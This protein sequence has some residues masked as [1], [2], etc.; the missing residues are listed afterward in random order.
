MKQVYISQSFK[1][2][3]SILDGY[4][5]VFTIIDANLKPFVN[6]F[7]GFNPIWIQTSEINK[8][9]ETVEEITGQL[10]E[11]GAHR[12][13]FI[14][15]VGG[16]ITTDIAG[17]VASTY[18]RGVKF[19]FV[20]TTLLAQADA[21]IGGKNGVNF[22]SYKNIIG[23][24]TQPEWIY[25]CPKV[26]S[27]LSLREFR[28]GVAEVLKTLI[29]FDREYY[30]VALD[31]FS[32][33]QQIY[34]KYNTYTPDGEFFKIQLLTDIIGKCAQYKSAVV[35]RDEFER[36]E[37][38]LLNFGHTFAHAIEKICG[39]AQNGEYELNGGAIMHGEAVAIGIVMAAKLSGRMGMASNGFVQKLENDLKSVGLPTEIPC[40]PVTGERISM[41]QIVDALKKDKKVSGEHINFILPQ[42]IGSVKDMKILIKDLEEVAGDLC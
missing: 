41:A 15:G 25:I 42:E 33:L 7:N 26:L 12:D 37:R 22:N 4:G 32:E 34:E 31:Y 20:P 23:T 1:E 19:G 17:F 13:S 36:G 18:K 10:L 14:I 38:R 28:A 40:N 27:S 8:T 5:S 35:E 29:L 16:G 39:E 3:K 2:L 9:L 24:I 6:I 21:S 11:M 30:K